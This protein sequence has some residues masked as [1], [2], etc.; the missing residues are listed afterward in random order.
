M[1]FEKRDSVIA[2]L[3]KEIDDMNEIVRKQFGA[4][5]SAVALILELEAALREQEMMLGDKMVIQS[6]EDKNTQ[7]WEFPDGLR[8]IFRDGKY[9]GWYLPDGENGR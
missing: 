8:L 6:V 9:V 1:C 3:R 2:G 7:Y 4:Y 5:Q